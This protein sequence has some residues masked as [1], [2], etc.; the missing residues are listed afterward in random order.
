MTI[1]GGRILERTS[2]IQRTGAKVH[3]CALRFPLCALDR[4]SLHSVVGGSFSV[5]PGLT[6]SWANRLLPLLQPLRLLAA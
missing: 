1:H 3:D 5:V 2:I 4:D 6:V